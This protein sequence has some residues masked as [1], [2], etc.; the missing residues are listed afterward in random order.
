MSIHETT[1]LF[2]TPTISHHGSKHLDDNKRVIIVASQHEI[3]A[4]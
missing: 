3:D 2:K 1:L 4:N